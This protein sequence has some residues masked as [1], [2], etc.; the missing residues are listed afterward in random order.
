MQA[1]AVV[2]SSMGRAVLLLSWDS[3][4]TMAAL[5]EESLRKPRLV[6]SR[7]FFND[8]K[9]YRVEQT[10]CFAPE[11]DILGPVPL[12]A[13]VGTQSS[14]ARSHIRTLP[15]TPYS[16]PQAGQLP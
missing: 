3:M 10:T 9:C 15:R 12:I 7:E 11:H 13:E 2:G 14:A 5:P 6:K 8:G 1:S 16:Q 4:L